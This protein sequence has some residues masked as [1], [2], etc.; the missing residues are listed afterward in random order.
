VNS[1]RHIQFFGQRPVGLQPFIVRS[2]P[3]ILPDGFAQR[4]DAAALHPRS[5]AVLRQRV[6]EHQRRD[7]SVGRRGPPAV[8]DRLIRPAGHRLHDVVLCQKP[9]GLL[10]ERIAVGGSRNRRKP[11]GVLEEAHPVAGESVQVHVDD[12]LACATVAGRLI[13]RRLASRKEECACDEEL[14]LDGAH[15]I[16]PSR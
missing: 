14:P 6:K 9:K 5:N 7:D 1:D 10:P 15:V 12:R 2:H 4:A 8:D 11:A 16:P 3:L 13:A